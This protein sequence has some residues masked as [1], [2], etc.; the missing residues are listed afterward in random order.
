M[1]R[2]TC[3]AI[4]AVEEANQLRRLRPIARARHEQLADGEQQWR[5]RSQRRTNG[6]AIVTH[7]ILTGCALVNKLCP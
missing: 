1:Q 6:L 2:V 3:L 5:R 7:V 4:S